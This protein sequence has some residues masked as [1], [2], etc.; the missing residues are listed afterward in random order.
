[1][2]IAGG[3]RDAEHALGIP[4][5]TDFFFPVMCYDLWSAAGII[6]LDP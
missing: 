4:F 2:V 5:I 6:G 1:M 3:G